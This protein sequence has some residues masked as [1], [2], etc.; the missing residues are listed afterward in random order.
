MLTPGFIDNLIGNYDDLD[1]FEELLQD[2]KENEMDFNISSWNEKIEDEG[3]ENIYQELLLLRQF[4]QNLESDNQE[5]L[6]K[7]LWLI[8]V[9]EKKYKESIIDKMLNYSIQDILQASEKTNTLSSIDANHYFV[10]DDCFFDNK[11]SWIEQAYL[12][13][14]SLTAEKLKGIEFQQLSEIL[15]NCF[16]DKKNESMLYNIVLNRAIKCV[17]D[18]IKS[19]YRTVIKELKENIKEVEK[20]KSIRHRLYPE[21]ID[22]QET[23]PFCEGIIKESINKSLEENT[24]STKSNNKLDKEQKKTDDSY[25][26][27][28]LQF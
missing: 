22:G 10:E 23:L 21:Y 14:K 19:Q 7:T 28:V 25:Q 11:T 17:V 12:Y 13:F 6:N 27:L 2:A 26:Q 20:I 3:Y 16:E 1:T 4:I 5:L 18:S 8:R 24:T 9:L 15:F